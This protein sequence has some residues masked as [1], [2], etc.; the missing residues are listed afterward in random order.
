MERYTDTLPAELQNTVRRIQARHGMKFTTRA[1]HAHGQ[2]GQAHYISWRK[3]WCDPETKLWTVKEFT[4]L[5][6]VYSADP[7][8]GKISEEGKT[9]LARVCFY[10]ALYACAKFENDPVSKNLPVAAGVPGPEDDVPHYSA[11]AADEGIPLAED[12]GMPLIALYGEI[13][14]DGIFS[15]QAR[16]IARASAGNLAQA[17]V[18][19]TDVF[20]A[21]GNLPVAA[22]ARAM[23]LSLD[24]QRQMVNLKNDFEQANTDLGIVYRTIDYAGNH[25]YGALTTQAKKTL[26]ETGI[27]LGTNAAL[28]TAIPLALSFGDIAF[29]PI[30]LSIV[31]GIVSALLA[32]VGR[33]WEGYSDYHASLLDDWRDRDTGAP[34]WRFKMAMKALR[35]QIEK[36]PSEGDWQKTLGQTADE[37]EMGFHMLW[38]R[39][40]CRNDVQGKGGWGQ[41]GKARRAF[42]K[43]C[44]ARG[45]GAS[46]IENMAAQ[47]A[48]HLD[49]NTP[50]LKIRETMQNKISALRKAL[51]KTAYAL[52]A[53]PAP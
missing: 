38:L 1:F 26:R 31:S 2:E 49:S 11:F 28:W 50:D 6:N 23:T 27:M 42:N 5:P 24:Q 46:E 34:R 39:Q 47:L 25:N 13:L 21:S 48:E 4:T 10:D 52:D 8:A 44:A 14:E 22:P 19:V 53:I 35:R 9:V 36:L 45:S 20:A 30:V 18:H 16:A 37:I 17:P 51:Q 40:V 32:F 29:F 7:A 15:P 43:I 12:T 33:P 3:A 41:L